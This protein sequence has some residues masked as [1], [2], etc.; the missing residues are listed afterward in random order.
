M[1]DF[2]K[3]SII[4]LTF[5]ST[6]AL[7]AEKTL[8]VNRSDTSL[9]EDKSS[10]AKVS[11]TLQAGTPVTLLDGG[12]F[13]F[14]KVSTSEG[15]I[16]YIPYTSL[17]EK[18]TGSSQNVM[19]YV[20]SLTRPKDED[21]D[22]SRS[23]SANAVMGIR[24]LASTDDASL[25]QINTSRPDIKSVLEMEERVVQSLRLKNLSDLIVQ[26]NEKGMAP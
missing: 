26:E 11:A 2:F 20:R 1:K 18:A 4:V 19:N 7:A 16:G 9:L 21:V 14:R 17:S 10:K 13:L 8:F 25:G 3:S 23:R 24:G 22:S 15:K 6:A 12:N 5:V